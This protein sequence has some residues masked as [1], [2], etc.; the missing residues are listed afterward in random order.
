V[1][2]NSER[3][4]VTTGNI[5]EAAHV[6]ELAMFLSKLNNMDMDA[7]DDIYKNQVSEGIDSPKATAGLGF[8]DIRRKTASQL[9]YSFVRID[10]ETSFFIFTSTVAR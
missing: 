9:D 4:Q 7:L 8:I 6:D 1:A 10:E 3:F 5:V 2:K